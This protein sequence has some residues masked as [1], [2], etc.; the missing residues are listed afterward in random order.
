[1]VPLQDDTNMAEAIDN[2]LSQGSPER[3][4]SIADAIGE[5]RAMLPNCP[6]DDVRLSE[7]I[8]ALAIQ[9]N[10]NVSFDRSSLSAARSTD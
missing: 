8:A 6:L 2:Y 4:I 7:L 10:R 3:I 5:L 1:M 9:R